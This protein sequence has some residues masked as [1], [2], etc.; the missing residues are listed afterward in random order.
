M[1]SK[2]FTSGT[3]IDA[4]WLN[5]VNTA[6]YTTVPAL[7]TT[8]SGLTTSVSGKADAGVNADITQL[9]WANGVGFGT[10]PLSGINA[11]ITLSGGIKFPAVPVA[12]SDPTT[13]DGY[14][15]GTFTPTLLLGG[16]STSQSYLV[17]VGWYTRIG[18]RVFFNC[19]VYSALLGSGTGAVTIGNLPYTVLSTSYNEN[20]CV[21]NFGNTSGSLQIQGSAYPGTTTVVLSKTSAGSTTALQKTDLTNSSYI[22]ISG[23]YML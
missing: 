23:Q 16:S 7:N 19:Q 10:A 5:D 15:E 22:I 13:L 17:Q 11:S 8:V 4:P 18:N 21:V 6:T 2:T 9:N 12:S 1:T 3:V 20:P 14:A